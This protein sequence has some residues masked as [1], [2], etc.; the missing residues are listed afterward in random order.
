MNRKLPDITESVTELK[1]RLRKESVGYKKERLTAL[2]LL[3]SGLARHRKQ[4][5][6]LIGVS[7]ETVGHWLNAYEDGG[8]EQMLHRSSPPG[9]PPLLSE[10]QLQALRAELDK[11]SG[12]SSYGQIQ[13]FIAD[14]YQVE[15]SYKAVYSLIHDKWGAKPK[16]PRKSHKKKRDTNPSLRFDLSIPSRRCYFRKTESVGSLVLPRRIEIWH[17]ARCPKKNHRLWYQTGGNC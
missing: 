11:P 14:T 12:F 1:N 7:R 13:Q 10:A 8:I 17:F 2:Y 15:M 3:Q 6:T 9:R 5:A 16:V 4:V